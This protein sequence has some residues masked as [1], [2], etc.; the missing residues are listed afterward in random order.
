M[1][2]IKLVNIWYKYPGAN[3]YALKNINLVFEDSKIYFINGPNGAGKTTLLLIIAGLIEPVRGE[4]I[5]RGKPLKQQLPI[6]RRY[7]GLLFQNPEHMLFNPTVYDEIAYVL[8]Q[9]ISDE[10][11][12]RERVHETIKCLGLEKTILNKYTYMLS[13]GEKKL[14]ALAAI[15][16]Y[17]PDIL[18]L[19]EP[20]TNLSLKYLDKIKKI[21]SNYKRNGKTVIVAGHEQEFQHEEIDEI[22]L[23]ENGEVIDHIVYSGS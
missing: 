1:E 6:A 12:I 2:V 3:D 10:E 14:V 13:Y 8:R 16:S 15:L 20:F 19:D 7:F 17:E 5:F 21:I 11:E 22:I 4:V 9:L 18:L 23:L